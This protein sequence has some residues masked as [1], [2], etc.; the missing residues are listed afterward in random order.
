MLTLTLLNKSFDE[1]FVELGQR[2]W[3]PNSFEEFSSEAAALVSQGGL[4]EGPL[5]LSCERG[6]FPS[7]ESFTASIGHARDVTWATRYLWQNL[8][9]TGAPST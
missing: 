9:P 4:A 6:I 8:M 7:G 1:R 3:T 2:S 5:F